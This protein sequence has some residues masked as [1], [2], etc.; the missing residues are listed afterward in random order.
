MELGLAIVGGLILL[1]I[2]YF[3]FLRPK[4]TELTAKEE[5]SRLPPKE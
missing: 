5:P 1:A 2:L 4:S 3:A